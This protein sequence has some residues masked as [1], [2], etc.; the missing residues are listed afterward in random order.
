[1]VSSGGGCC[2]LPLLPALPPPLPVEFGSIIRQCQQLHAVCTVMC[3]IVFA[4]ATTTTTT[5]TT[6]RVTQREHLYGTHQ[7][8]LLCS[9]FDALDLGNSMNIRDVSFGPVNK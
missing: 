9:F 8:A 6:T 1:M 5:T 7:H 4:Y 2:P 3:N